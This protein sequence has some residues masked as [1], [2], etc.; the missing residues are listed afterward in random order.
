MPTPHVLAQLRP[1]LDRIATGAAHRE[2]TRT[3][4]F[5]PV[6]WLRDAGFGALR[7]P[8]ELGGAGLDL[9]GLVEV[10]TE[11]AR[12]DPNVAHLWRGHFAVVEQALLSEDP[13]RRRRWADA[14]VGGV[15]VGNAS[16][17]QGNGGLWDTR[18]RLTQDDD[19]RWWLDGLKY[20]STG[21]IFA[22]WVNVG[23]VLPDGTRAGALVPVT[24]PGVRVED[25]W[26]GFG[27]RLTGSGTTHLDRV[28]VDARDITPFGAVRPAFLGAY[29]QLYL[30]AVLCGIGRAVVDDAVAFVRPRT[31]TFGRGDAPEPRHDPLVQ[32]VVGRLG[33]A[34]FAADAATAAAA[35]RLGDLLEQGPTATDDDATAADVAV[36]RAQVVVCDAV[37]RA[38]T[39]LFEVGGASATA[40]D[41]GLDRHW[42]NARTI[43]CHNPVVEKERLLGDHL[44]NGTPPS[45][46]FA[47][48]VPDREPVLAR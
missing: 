35:A 32:G 13:A 24:A 46:T 10:V 33:A 20:Y 18:T 14:V 44:L 25:D 16:S 26:D 7:V 21:T 6:V 39:E 31:R 37:L 22:D 30:L 5:E 47:T 8:T 4:P 34:S 38:A 42:R 15:V 43:A 28:P 41:R 12:V 29:Y 27:Q 1:T 45:A 11:V 17:E 40:T 3:L 19:G 2:R 23:A 9:P 48:R 36:Y